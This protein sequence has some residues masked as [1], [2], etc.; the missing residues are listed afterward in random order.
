MKFVRCFLFPY[1]GVVV[2]HY[3][4]EKCK[5]T[6][7]YQLNFVKDLFILRFGQ[8]YR[9]GTLIK[10]YKIKKITRIKDESTINIY[11]A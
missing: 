5:Y 3:E 2:V 4:E 10:Q 11:S 1:Q 7:R 8:A 9:Y 6:K